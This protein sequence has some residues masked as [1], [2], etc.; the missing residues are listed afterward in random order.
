MTNEITER[1]KREEEIQRLSC[2]VE[3]SPASVVI[4][5]SEGKIEYINPKFTELTGY[6]LEDVLG[7]TPRI[8]KSGKASLEEYRKLWKTIKSGSEW[9]GEFCNRKKNGVLYWEYKSILP[10]RNAEGDI[11]NFVAV[12]EDITKRRQIEDALKKSQKVSLVK[13]KEAF[14]AQKRAE[15]I[16]ITEEILGKLLHLSHQPLTIQDF[17][18]QALDLILVSIPWLNTP[19][20]GAIFLTDKSEQAE[21]L[22][23]IT[24][25]HLSS[26]LQL[27]CAHVPFG[28]CMCG[29]A[30]AT[31]DIQFSDCIDDRHDIHFEGMAPHGHYNIPIIHENNTLGVLV[32]YL[33]EGHKR[34]EK[35]EI[36]LRKLSNV[37]SI[38]IAHRNA[39]GAR[40][41]AEEALHKETE[42][43]RLLQEV[44]VTSNVASSVDEAM[45]TCIGKL[46]TF[47]K[48][49]IGH[50]YL[51][52]SNGT[53]VPSDLWFF[54]RH[55]KYEVFKKVTE[56]TTFTKGVGLPG[57]VLESGKPAWITDLIKDSNFPRAKI[58]EDLKV[59]SGFAFPVLERN[60]VVAVLEFF[61]PE[62]LEPDEYLL[63]IIQPLATQLGRVTERK[64]A[65]EQLRF[66]KEAAESANTSKGTFLANM[67]H[68]I[69]TP[70]NGIMGMA[71]LLLDTK[72]THEQRKYA[73]TVRDSTDALLTV[74]NDILDFSKIEA[75][76]ME[77]ENINF[78][79]R[80]AVE[81]VTDI[82]AV[83][84]HDKG[85]ELSCFISPEVPSL[86]RGDPGR[87]RQVLINLAGN[88]VKFTES[89]E[90]GISV[91]MVEETKSNITVR[92]DIKDTGVGIPVDRMDRLFK[93]FSQADA[94]TTRQYGGTGL[95]LAI[96]KQI[97]ELMGGQ[98]GLKSE[99]GEGTT[100]WFT[101]VMEKQPY[102]QQQTPIEL[103]DIKNMRVLIVGDN[104][105][106]RY[107]FRKYLES[108]H[109]CVGE[110][111]SDE[112]AIKKLREAVNSKDPFRIALLDYCMPEVD[113]ESLCMEIKADLQF[114]DL[115]L[116]MLT[117]FGS[118][119]DAEHFKELGFA[120]YL[121]K[122]IKQSLLLD[123]LRIVTGESADVDEYTT[124]QIVTQ[125]SISEDRKQHVRILLAEDN[126][127]NQK[128]ALHILEK[129]LGYHADVVTTGKEAIESLEK[130]DYDLVLMDCQMPEMDGYEATSTIRD[131][132]SAVRNHNI[133]IV[134][135]TAN[136]MKGDREKC[137][138]AG[139]DDYVSKP[140]NM[141]DLADAIGRYLHN[142]SVKEK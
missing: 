40:E 51:L 27:L 32:L 30:A 79:L 12:N 47:T 134:A 52:D 81:S 9:R 132:N 65:E 60:N 29:K 123:C 53:L 37:L 140:I 111:I 43:I 75:G 8:L 93:S 120:A 105:T 20:H 82:L 4:T 5:D 86:L 119:G 55:K 137:L 2:A 31:R 94:S 100:F 74:I 6:T 139:M 45:R 39:D 56:S 88:A 135:M 106:N 95:G 129:K 72:L 28:K 1:R 21:T 76:K 46:C 127:V 107:I 71:D 36:F 69:R 49:S 128:V 42:L 130:F 25:H 108:W 61:S 104:S 33:R 58:A 124:S 113:G 11:I 62:I 121:H 54:D 136:A 10:I 24:N 110:A 44:A 85:L 50:V 73:N 97:T 18:R 15:N 26:E 67:S 138:E 90:V 122:P 68:E 78:D 112:E 92:F 89:G 117:S 48:F 99:E 142:D 17:L 64:R 103:R 77:I 57:R 59:K 131:L 101:A 109:C 102:D 23:L 133:P 84:A 22:K 141:Q 16:A 66:A 98:I 118:R 70:M 116:V 91:I 34:V 35:E 3:Q 14:E 7:Q 19:P 38:G 63:Q 114:N 83:K 41:K 96:S 80:I 87:L 125:Y 13:M 115:I 126:V